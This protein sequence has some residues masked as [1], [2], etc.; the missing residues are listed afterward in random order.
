M[1][2][3]RRAP[4][5]RG[6]TAGPSRPPR[7]LYIC[8]HIYIYTYVYIYIYIYRERERERERQIDIFKISNILPGAEGGP[9]SLNQ[10]HIMITDLSV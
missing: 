9:S 8:I 10:T 2:K 6:A 1:N 7:A 4:N 3:I 5:A